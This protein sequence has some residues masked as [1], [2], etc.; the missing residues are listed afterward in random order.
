M[1]VC[2]AGV[3]RIVILIG[4]WAIKL[5]RFG[6]GWA[7]GLRGLL[8]NMQERDFASTGWP[9]LCPVLWSGWGG[10]VLVMRR[11]RELTETEW[12]RFDYDA[13]VRRHESDWDID[14]GSLEQIYRADGYVPVECKAD[15]FG[16]LD[17]RI[18]ALDYGS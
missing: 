18:V 16:I 17:G 11:A 6:Y 3:T 8:C 5:P 9:E 10:W 2:R 13:F 14:V 15:S 1:R 7:L 4:P 12:E